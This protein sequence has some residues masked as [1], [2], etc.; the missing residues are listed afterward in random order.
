MRTLVVAAV[1]AGATAAAVSAI[2]APAAPSSAA[3]PKASPLAA[4]SEH[5]DDAFLEWPLAPADRAYGAIDGRQLHRLVGEQA[6][7]SRRY[8][9][10]GEAFKPNYFKIL[11]YGGSASPN[12]ILEEAGIDIASAEFWQGGFDMITEFIDQLEALEK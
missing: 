1:V 6:A 8:R 12:H 5:F 4:P 7:I 2:Q 11:S 10:Q 9:D 3:I